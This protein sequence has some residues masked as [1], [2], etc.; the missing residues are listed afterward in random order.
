MTS[1][2]TNADVVTYTSSADLAVSSPNV[3]ESSKTV[4]RVSGSYV[5]G[6]NNYTITATRNANAATTVRN[7]AVSIANTA[8]T[9]AI[10]IGGSPARLISSAAGQ[11]YTVTLTFN[12]SMS[13]APSLAASSGS[14]SGAWSGSG[15]T[16]SRTL[17]IND[18]AP[19]GS[20]LFGAL[21]ATG[22]A[23]VT[24]STITSGSAYTVGGFVRKTLTFAAFSQMAAIGTS[25]VD[26]TKTN[27]KY[28]GAQLNLTRRTDTADAVA[29][30]TIV[31]SG[32]TYDPTG[33]YLFINDV[34]FAG[35][36]TTGTL[37][38]EIE[39]VV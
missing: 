35:S 24:A 33:N 32:G 34:A 6:T 14:W 18:S 2:V 11:S 36:N 12:Q 29:S 26:I 1:V 27:A 15:T 30:Y 19:K 8:A 38:V 16:W 21:S 25:V 3:Y 9:A 4:T 31:N 37:Q 13:S 10:T 5:V 23:G 28:A 20:Q 7:A 22:L 17:I 39:E